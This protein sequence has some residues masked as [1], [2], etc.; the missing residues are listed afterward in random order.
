[1]N[2][3]YILSGLIVSILFSCG[4]EDTSPDMLLVREIID[5][6][7]Y[8][9]VFGYENDRLVVFKRYLADR[10]STH[11]TFQYQGNQ[12]VK[13]EVKRDQGLEQII[14]LTY[15][16]DGL[17]KEEKS[18]T[19]YQGKVTYVKNGTFHYDKGVLIS[20]KYTSND[21]NY[22]PT[23]TCLKWQ[24]GNLVKMTYYF[25]DEDYTYLAS[26]KTVTYDNKK[27][28]SNQDIAFIYILGRESETSL[29][30]NN[31]TS[32]T[33]FFG[34]TTIDRGSYTFTYNKNGYPD[35]YVYNVDS[36]KY[37]PMQLRY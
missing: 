23:E 35:G 18:T 21:P 36:Q 29:S 13:I 30:K 1:M 31:V 8:K 4:T 32:T 7:C 27:N 9:D 15:G 28:Y 6:T 17:R 25:F 2:L 34:G 33:E 22:F 14:E 24:N 10:I 3:R 5:P 20:I 19:I 26:E 37:G 12:L 16:E 11:T